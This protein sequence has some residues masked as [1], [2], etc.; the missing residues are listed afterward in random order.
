LPLPAQRRRGR[1]G[2]PAPL[3]QHGGIVTRLLKWLG[4]LLLIWLLLTVVPVL[5][6]RW[7]C[8]R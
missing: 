5:L 6:L 3:R 2:A 7:R 8:H 1:S 4:S